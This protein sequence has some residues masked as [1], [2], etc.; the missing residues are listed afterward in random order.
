M[1]IDYVDGVRLYRSVTAGL[2]RVVSRQDYLNKINVFPVPDG[3]TGTNMAYTLSSIEDGINNQIFSDVNQMSAAIADAALDGARGNSGAILAQFLVGFA[4]GARDCLQ[5]TTREFGNA[6][7]TA[8]EFAYEA[9]AKPKEGTILSVISDWAED[10]RSKSRESGDFRPVLD[11]ALACARDSLAQT[12][13]KLAVLAKAGVVDAGAQGFVDFMDGI[14]EFVL[15][16][17]VETVDS[18]V[19]E[20]TSPETETGIEEQYQYCTECIITSENIDRENLRNR[21]GDLGDSLVLAGTR[22]KAKIHIHTDEP[23]SVVDLCAEFGLVSGEKA[24]D[25]LRQ[26]RDAQREHSSTAL[27]VDSGCDLPDDMIEELD[28]HV[29]PVR[30]NFGD[31]HFVDKMTMSTE[32]FWKE[33]DTNP[34]H[35]QTSQ[36]TPGDF[37]RQYQ[38]LASHFDSAISIH[39]PQSVSGTYQSAVNATKSLR[40]FPLEVI[41]CQSGTVGQGLIAWRAAEALKA[42]LA[43]EETVKIINTAV[44]NTSLFIGLDTLDSVVRGGRVPASVRSV[45]NALRLNPILSL[46]DKGVKP[47]GKTFGSKNKHQKFLNWLIKKLPDEVPFRIGIGHARC[48]DIAQKFKLEFEQR[49]GAE[50]VFLAELGPALSVHAGPKAIAVGIQTLEDGLNA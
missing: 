4:D 35:P 27:V 42:G 25:M 30:L 47:V 5:L 2:K 6:V 21:L 23:K 32:E 44:T 48:E 46:T 3:D 10:I 40:D 9:L 26:Q 37:R 16:G 49:A 17:A 29:V 34:V 7:K 19:L 38:M 8:K 18:I 36:P 15:N 1:A 39:I 22:S 33:L 12:P 28:I 14:Q 24:D 11:S 31:Q 43:M 45:A 41:D 20:K 13:E 50:N